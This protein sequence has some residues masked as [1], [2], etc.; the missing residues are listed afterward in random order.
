MASPLNVEFIKTTKSKNK[1]HIQSLLVPDRYMRTL[2][3]ETFLIFDSGI[4]DTNRMLMFSTPKMLSLL[5]ESQ[6]GL[7]T[8]RLKLYLNN[9][10]SFIL[11][12]L[13]RIVSLFL[14]YILC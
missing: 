13:K 9:F 11:Y 8:V 1:A 2:K 10:F 4:G 12:M 7:Q 14:V 6:G 5:Q 3:D